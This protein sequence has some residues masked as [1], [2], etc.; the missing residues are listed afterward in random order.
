MRKQLEQSDQLT[1]F[2]TDNLLSTIFF[3]TICS[4]DLCRYCIIVYYMLALAP[5]K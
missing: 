5:S 4:P 2:I 3:D 1:T